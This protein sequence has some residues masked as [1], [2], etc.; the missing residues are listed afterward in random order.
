[1]P[2]G[3]EFVEPCVYP[4]GDG[5]EDKHMAELYNLKKDPGETKNLISDSQ[6]DAKKRELE[7]QLA[8]LMEASGIGEDKMPK[9]EGVKKEL[10]DA[11]IR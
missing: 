6:Y 2:C 9:D 7:V 3:I 5:S 11:K 8:V 10:P 4:P 1:L